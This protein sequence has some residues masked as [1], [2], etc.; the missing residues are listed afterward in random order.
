MRAAAPRPGGRSP[1]GRPVAVV[2]LGASAGLCLL[3]DRYRYRYLDADGG[4]HVVGDG[5][6]ELIVRGVRGRASPG[7]GT[8]D[9]LARRDRPQPARPRRPGRRP[10][11]GAAW[12]GPSTTS[13][14]PGSRPRS[15][16]P[17]PTRR[18]WC[19]ATSRTG[20]ATLL[21]EVPAGLTTV[22]TH[23]AALAYVP[24]EVG[25]A[26]RRTC[27]EAGAW[28]LGAEGQR[29]LPDLTAPR[30]RRRGGLPG[31]GGRPG[32]AATRWSR[33]RSRTAGGCA[34]R[35]RR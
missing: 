12:S 14:P 29:V 22:V 2:E 27:R 21:A 30:R 7:R 18:G 28:R 11:A 8:R 33:W 19:A 6:P 24:P 26:V 16:P 3:Y 34:G 9:P 25:D 31:L 15:P 20:L 5:T 13:A 4:E 17:R 35:R 32:R 23:T 1:S 10:V